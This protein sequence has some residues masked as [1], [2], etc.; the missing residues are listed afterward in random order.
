MSKRPKKFGKSEKDF[1]SKIL[2]IL[3]KDVNKTFNYKQIG[4][5]L[6]LD[7]TQSRN[8]IIKDLKILAAQN[9]IEEVEKGKYKVIATQDYY[10]GTIDMTSRRTAYFVSPEFE[11]DIFIPTNNLNKALDGDKVKIYVYNRRRGRKPEGEVVEIIE[12]KK[13]EFVGVIDIQKNFAFVSTANA[14]MY[15]DIFIPKNKLGEAENGDV[16]LVKIEDWPEK[17]D[18]PFGAVIKVLGKPGEHNTEIHAILAEYGLPYDFPAEVEA[19]AEKLDT[20]IQASEIANRRDMRDTL[21]FTIDPKDAKDF[22]DALSFKKL[23]NGNY[24][25][26]IHIA[27]VSYYL[28]EG[29][30]LD[31]EAYRRGTS[32]YLV[33][34]VVPMLPEVLSNFAC[35][36]RPNEEK[37]TFSAVFEITEKAV[38]VNQWFG[39]T[40]IYSDQRFA[41]EEAQY[42]IETKDNVI[43]E[44]ISITGSSYTVNDEI[45]A[46]TLKLDELAK[47]FR[48]KRMQQG[49]I[50]FDK[51]EVKFN[52]NENHEPVGVYFKTSKDA[53]HLIE[54]FMLLANRKVAE[55]IGKQKKTFVY[56]I[57]DEPNEDKLIS[58]QTVISKFGYSINLKTKGDISKSL[59]TLL[60]DIQGKKEQNLIDTLTIRTMSKAKYST[61]NIGH[62]GLAFDYYSHF[63]SPIRRYPD[64]MVHRLLQYYLDGGKSVDAEVYEEKCIHASN[65]ESLAT[66]A[67]RDS[68]K[69]MQVKY[70]QDHQN[71]EFLGVISGVTEWGIYVEIMDNKCEGMCRI[72]EIRDDYYT[73]DEKQY[74]LVGEVSHN[75]LQ[76][77]DEVFVKV[78]NADL[79]KKQLDFHFIK[80]ND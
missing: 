6:E 57:H 74:A 75:T 21:T 36:L 73:F 63:T 43:P 56:R 54:E 26:G 77:G 20:S 40:V 13:L 72:R 8:Q 1:T 55:Y 61:E 24:E 67:E 41:Y 70:M 71:E 28:Q 31:E 34:R 22:D 51:V 27:D 39:R 76:L 58:L 49:A 79:V 25:I 50:S 4:A 19:Y 32:V 69:Y 10:E 18:S 2:K 78:K 53:N 47:I 29:T 66:N 37:Y 35:S 17:A 14:K 48:S 23:E 9:K 64:V 42:I 7:D 62:Y 30:L 33:D 65:M 45:V 16:V 15:T 52:L 38:V 68:I 3:S 12:R 59:N 5:K 11:D 46:A 44:E 60:N 80:K